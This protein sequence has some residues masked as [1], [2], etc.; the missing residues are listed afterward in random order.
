[1][2]RG[3]GLRTTG[4]G[5]MHVLF[6]GGTGIIS[7]ACARLALARGIE[8]TFLCRGKTERH[9][10]PAGVTVLR[11]DIRDARS[12]R[13][14]LGDRRFDVIVQFIGFLPSHVQ[15]DIELFRGR[16]RQYVFISSAS[17]YQTPPSSVPVTESTALQN[18][19]WQYSRDKIAC[20]EQL[21]RAHRTDGF[22]V[23][24]V[25]PS[26]TYDVGL[27]PVHGGWT[28]VDRMRRGL[29][30]IVHGDGTSLWTLTHCDDF[31]RGFIGLL[32]QPGAI[33]DTFHI[34]SDMTLTWDR[35]HEILGRAA[36]AR[37]KLVHVPSD[38][39]SAFDPEWGASLL[40]DKAHS[41]VFDNTKIKRV[42][43]DFRA[44]IPYARAAEE[45]I[46]WYD[47][48]ERRR[49][50]DEGANAMIDRILARYGRAW[51]DAP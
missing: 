50:V 29:P 39:I 38:L 30:V 48:D 21:I 17:V 14:A 2:S 7:A 22:P 10:A 5:A 27:L 49:V 51:P 40:G 23:T 13:S 25:R 20:E 4:L 45:Q 37:P 34:T 11:G 46:A 6:V 32:G 47:E 42:V 18:P 8:V 26:H 3:G 31:A 41:M 33:G 16:T 19:Y 44:V 9:P 15:L 1:M 43:P 12:A 28:V 36:G 24:I 35:I